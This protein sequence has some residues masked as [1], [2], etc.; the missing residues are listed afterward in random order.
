MTTTKLGKMVTHPYSQMTLDKLKPLYLHYHG[1]YGYQLVNLVLY[2][3][4][5]PSR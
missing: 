2:L 1:A 5:L 4:G 3:E